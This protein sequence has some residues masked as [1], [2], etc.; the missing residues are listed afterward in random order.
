MKFVIC[1]Y[2]VMW[3]V[4][5][6][7]GQ[8]GLYML[9]LIFCFLCSAQNDPLTLMTKSGTLKF[10]FFSSLKV[11]MLGLFFSEEHE[12]QFFFLNK[13]SHNYRDWIKTIWTW[14]LKKI[15]F[16]V[17]MKQKLNQRGILVTVHTPGGNYRCACLHEDISINKTNDWGLLGIL[18]KEYNICGHPSVEK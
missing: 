12:S 4:S 8:V 11:Y 16:F 17:N 5:D 7:T 13:Q 10:F 14:K 9:T 6:H 18:G 3:C 1:S 15:L 2:Y